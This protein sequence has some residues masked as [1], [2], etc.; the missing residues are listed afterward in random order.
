MK[1]VE[2]LRLIATM[3]NKRDNLA[4]TQ[5]VWPETLTG[6]CR[7]FKALKSLVQDSCQKQLGFAMAPAMKRPAK[8]KRTD[9]LKDDS[10][11]FL[12]R[13]EGRWVLSLNEEFGK[14]AKGQ[15]EGSYSFDPSSGCLS[16]GKHVLGRLVVRPLGELPPCSTDE[17]QNKENA[18]A[19][20]VL[21][22]QMN[23]AEYP[24]CVDKAIVT[25]VNDY[26]YDRTAGP[27]GQLAG[28]LGCAQFLLDNAKSTIRRSGLD[29]LSRL[30]PALRDQGVTSQ[31]AK[32]F[33]ANLEVKNGYLMVP[34]LEAEDATSAMDEVVGA[35]EAQLKKL[36]TI[37]MLDIP[38]TGLSPSLESWSRCRHTVNLVYASAV[39]VNAYSNKTESLEN[40]KLQRSVAALLL[41][42][43]YF[44]ALKLA[45]E[46]ALSKPRSKL[47]QKV[48]LL[49]LGGGVFN[50]PF[51]DIVKAILEAY[52]MVKCLPML[53]NGAKLDDLLDV[54]V[55]TWKGKPEEAERCTRRMSSVWMRSWKRNN[56]PSVT[57][58]LVN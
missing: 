20:F 54:R 31:E 9:T 55:L 1:H 51:K 46:T 25:E 44:G 23:A 53:P 50:N 35:V 29:A 22:S 33:L 11:A 58:V 13:T 3:R 43:A 49:P 21:P 19:F 47:R 28:H 4:E 52:H 24:D 42:G 10:L 26:R 38:A 39:P 15:R 40:V 56:P 36:R 18:G 30:L 12:K 17:M 5:A 6:K 2:T 27:R 32:D 34:E 41:R 48:F 16:S 8:R 37:A 14:T 57:T 45:L 7:C